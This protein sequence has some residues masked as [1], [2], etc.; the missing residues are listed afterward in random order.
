[1]LYI[2]VPYLWGGNTPAGFDCSG[3][4]KY[5]YAKHGVTLPRIAHDQYRHSRRV[6]RSDAR[7]GDLVFML[8]ADGVAYHVGIYVGGGMMIDAPRRGLLVQKRKVWDSAA[9]YGRVL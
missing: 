6:D 5:V 2:G 1:M 4:T 8:G 3:F 9:R 7:E